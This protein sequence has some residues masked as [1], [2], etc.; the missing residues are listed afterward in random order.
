MTDDNG[1][2]WWEFDDRDTL[3][4]LWH[5]KSL[6]TGEPALWI[7]IVSQRTR[8]TG[9]FPLSGWLE[10]EIGTIETPINEILR[11]KASISGEILCDYGSTLWMFNWCLL[12]CLVLPALATSGSLSFS[13][14]RPRAHK[15]LPKKIKNWWIGQESSH[16]KLDGLRFFRWGPLKSK[17]PKYIWG[18]P[19]MGVSKMD[20]LSW[21]IL[22]R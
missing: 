13:L 10:N 15:W 11:G 2:W 20:G 6:L 21:E 18:F 9:H 8:F 12:S 16:P 4:T 7:G 14:D 17:R 22:L 1:W 5:I 3:E 19:Y